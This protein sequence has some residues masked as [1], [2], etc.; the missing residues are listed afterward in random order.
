MKRINVGVIG[1]GHLGS[2]H[3]RIYS[4]MDG[5]V[6]K[7]VCD[8]DKKRA[9]DVARLCSTQHYTDYNDLLDKVDAVSIV[10]PTELHYKIAKDFLRHGVHVLVEK[11]I[12]RTLSEANRLL[13]I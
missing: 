8:C 3:A 9:E 6:L 11:P 7:G 12:T 4:T 1:V 13:E 10:V 5:V 2:V